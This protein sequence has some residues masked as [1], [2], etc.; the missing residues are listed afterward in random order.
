VEVNAQ[1]R[2]VL[3]TDVPHECADG[4]A[5]HD[6]DRDGLNDVW[7][8]VVLQRLAPQVRLDPDDQLLVDQD[9]V[10]LAI[11]RVAPAPDRRIRV[12]VVLTYSHDY[13]RC[14]SG[15][16]AGDTE[17]VVLDL[18]ADATDPESWIVDRAY[19]AAHEG[20][21]GDASRLFQGASMRELEFV[22]SLDSG[23]PHWLVY[24]TRDKHATHAS[25]LR[26]ERAATALCL[27]EDCAAGAPGSIV[28]GPPGPPHADDLLPRAVNA[29][30]PNAPM[31]RGLGPF[32]FP[33]ED[34]WAPRP[35]C[36][37][38]D[39]GDKCADSPA[40]KLTLDPFATLDPL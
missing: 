34:C 40:V 19:T 11:G 26:C 37:G 1:R 35:F 24:S 31:I 14:G 36:G 38:L 25:S 4:D 18:A 30:E 10:F 5:C 13:G 17:R 12:F 33:G 2:M 23:E 32:G 16:H 15:G 6:E 9:A 3:T 8:D 27:E 28:A 20:V 22:L 29:G 21:D 39:V 7:E